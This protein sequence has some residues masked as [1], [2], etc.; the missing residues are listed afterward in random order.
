MDNPEDSTTTFEQL[1]PKNAAPEGGGLDHVGF[2]ELFELSPVPMAVY[3]AGY[4]PVAVNR[5]FCALLGVPQDVLLSVPTIDYFHPDEKAVAREGMEVVLAGGG[6]PPVS[7]FR[8]CCSDG[9]FRHI[10][11][12]SSLTTGVDGTVYLL[13]MF[14]DISEEVWNR[15]Q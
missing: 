9:I 6:V 7:E 1:D 14:R 8:V 11:M 10:E 12:S 3:S 5:A 2:G 4:V 15:G 13:V